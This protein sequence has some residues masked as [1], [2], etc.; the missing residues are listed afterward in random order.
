MSTASVFGL[1]TIASIIEFFGDSNFKLYARS[2]KWSNLFTGLVV[3]VVMICFVIRALKITNLLH[4]NA[5][6]DGMSA[7]VSIPMAYILL[8]E[9]LSN[10]V[11]Y[12]GL[13]MVIMGIFG[14]SYGKLPQ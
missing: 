4:A 14:L 7:L 9:T 10:P 1:I 12:A 8:H 13:A 2:G 3:Y 6:W 11:Q 5:I